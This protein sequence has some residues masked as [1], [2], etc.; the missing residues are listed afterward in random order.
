MAACNKVSFGKQDELGVPVEPTYTVCPTADPLAPTVEETEADDKLCCT[1]VCGT[2]VSEDETKVT[3]AEGSL[4][5]DL[6]DTALQALFAG[7]LSGSAVGDGGSTIIE[8]DDTGLTT[9]VSFPTCD[10]PD[11]LFTFQVD[12]SDESG[13]MYGSVYPDTVVDGF[14]ISQSVDECAKVSI[15]LSSSG[16]P[17]VQNET[18]D[19]D[20][21]ID[22]FPESALH[23]LPVKSNAPDDTGRAFCWSETAGAGLDVRLYTKDE[24]IDDVEAGISLCLIREAQISFDVERSEQ[25]KY[26][27]KDTPVRPGI[28]TSPGTLTWSI[29]GDFSPETL[30]FQA[31]MCAGEAFGLRFRWCLPAAK[32]SS[33]EDHFFDI[34][35][36]CTKINDGGS[37]VAQPSELSSISVGGKAY[38]DDRGL[39]MFGIITT[40]EQAAL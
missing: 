38:I 30:W 21:E 20:V 2:L 14:T 11:C 25:R 9:I 36:P 3:G 4:D 12:R 35:I 40:A 15:D 8:P 16:K 28:K 34:V 5:V 13:A 17:L 32:T 6:T 26:L 1:E 22:L 37:P 24:D 33:G 7:A 27:C 10:D 23:N 18:G 39:P 31:A 19:I 29:D